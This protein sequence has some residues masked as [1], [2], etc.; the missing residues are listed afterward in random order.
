MEELIEMKITDLIS[1]AVQRFRPWQV[2]S[3]LNRA[4]D[5]LDRSLADSNSYRELLA[6]AKSSEIDLIV[7]GQA[8]DVQSERVAKGAVSR[9][10]QNL[11]AQIDK[12]NGMAPR[13]VN[14]VNHLVNARTNLRDNALSNAEATLEQAWIA[15][16]RNVLEIL[17][18][19]QAFDWQQYDETN[20]MREHNDAKSQL[21]LRQEAI[22]EGQ[23]LDFNGQAKIVLERMARDVLEACEMLQAASSVLRDIYNYPD[24]FEEVLDGSVVVVTLPQIDKIIS[25]NRQAIRWLTAFGQNDQSFTVS[26]SLK[27]AL[28]AKWA[29]LLKGDTTVSFRLLSSQLDAFDFVRLRG[30][31]A[32]SIG[33]TLIL[34]PVSVDLQFP[35]K[36]KYSHKDAL[37]SIIDQTAIPTCRIGRVIDVRLPGNSE[38]YG[39]V[40]LMNASPYGVED[41]NGLFKVSI[42]ALVPGLLDKLQDVVVDLRLTGQPR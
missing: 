22:K 30:V 2:E 28:G 42:T 37:P 7:A 27:E 16:E 38:I 29:I 36:A 40:A 6:K 12:L 35:N 31:S 17:S 11:K 13:Y 32:T 9:V 10:L 15:R 33:Q 8:I 1:S 18:L 26:V 20:Q 41:S 34:H 5:L 14:A 21:V 25:W 19:T 23:P 39:Q 4:A 24:I 3:L